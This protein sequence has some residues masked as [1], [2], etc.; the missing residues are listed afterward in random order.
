MEDTDRR[1]IELLAADGRMSFTDLGRETGLS[2]SAVHQRV[3]RLE[4]RKVIRG[5]RAVIDPEAIGLP[6]MAIVAAQALD[7]ADT[8]RI[9]DR[10]AK[11]SR[12]QSCY[13]VAGSDSFVFTVR[14]PTPT[15]LEAL[16]AEIRSAARVSTRTSVVLSVP[17]EGR[18]VQ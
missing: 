2:T 10:L 9:P 4:R 12:I 5:Y 7:P 13:S 14:V 6:L 11:I 17:F 16:L 15:A 3:R 8:D 1:I 18:F